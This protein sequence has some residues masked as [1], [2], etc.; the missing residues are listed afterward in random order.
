MTRKSPADEA[1]IRFY[2]ATD[3][4]DAFSGTRPRP[5]RAGTDGP[6]ATIAAAQRLVRAKLKE[7]GKRDKRGRTVLP[8]PIRVEVAGGTYRLSKPLEFKTADSGQRPSRNA[9]TEPKRPVIWAAAEGQTP[10]FSGGKQ[11]TGFKPTTLANGVEAWVAS[12]P[13]ASS[14]KWW[15]RQLWVNGQRRL[16]PR[17]PKQGMFQ[18]QDLPERTSD[19][20]RF[21]KF[22]YENQK[23]YFHE[24]DIQDWRNMQDVEFVAIHFWIETRRRLASVNMKTRLARLAEPSR[25]RLTDDHHYD[26]AHYYIENVFEAL[27]EPGQWYLDRPA[28]K[29]YYVPMPGEDIQTVEVIAP[30]LEQV[31][32]VRGEPGGDRFV[33]SVEFHGLTFAHC[34]WQDTDKEM[35]KAP[36]AASH[37]L[38]A[39][40]VHAGRDIVFD[41]CTV[42]HVGA[43][44]M[45]FE[46]N[47]Y[48][49]RVSHCTVRDLG[50]GGIKVWAPSKRVELL[51]NHIHDGGYLFHSG[52][53]VLV[54]RCSGN[55]VAHNL[56][57]DFDYTGISVGWRWGY[58][59]G[60]AF[61]NVI[62]K[63]H[64]HTI[65]RGRLSDMGG[66]YTLGTSVGTR[67]RYNVFHNIQSRGYG[68]WCIYTDE[69]STGVLIEKNIGYDCK[70]GG[71]HQHYG[72]D[73]VV[74]NNI[75]AFGEVASVQWTQPEEP[76]NAFCFV[77]NIVYTEND[78][79]VIDSE[80]FLVGNAEVDHNLYYNPN[81]TR[82]TFAGKSWT[83]WRKDYGYDK[84]SQVGDPLF[85]DAA[86][87][88][89]RLK[90]KSPALAMGFEP[91]DV[92]DVGPRPRS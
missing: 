82:L 8:R 85:V 76:H 4:N 10:V 12:V 1:P 15:F 88:D 33:D 57:H 79:T 2:V 49:A 48:D 60:E 78:G 77:N 45:T 21:K 90:P 41:G 72:R 27:E 74:R 50:A 35:F 16:R 70:T 58:Q 9:R 59:E 43:Y 80:S 75:F 18:I 30:R 65:G 61:G 14:G 7:V 51:D 42:E 39:V 11:I 47:T 63:N 26:G 20:E 91:F 81:T 6:V 5:N 19:P 34:E 64:V 54:G 28:G 73:N 89:F 31:L 13:Q 84:N 17:L 38:A 25:L 52:V 24:G 29:L 36:Q 32:I 3:G 40:A 86:N 69:G 83:S 62:E 37:A 55:T 67:I 56:I 44:G 53:G 46:D 22:H 92:S 23:F 66:I 68:G 71:F 87:R